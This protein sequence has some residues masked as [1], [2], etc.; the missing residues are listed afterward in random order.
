MPTFNSNPIWLVEAIESVQNQLY[1]N[2]E[3]RIADDASVDQT[4]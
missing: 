4:T 1:P 2:W 3:L